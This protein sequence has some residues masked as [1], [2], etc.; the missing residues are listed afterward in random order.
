MKPESKLILEKILK[1][2]SLSVVKAYVEAIQ[3]IEQQTDAFTVKLQPK[4][5]G[6]P[7]IECIKE[8]R[9]LTGMGLKES[10]EMIEAGHTWT[11]L[12]IHEAQKLVSN[13]TRAGARISFQ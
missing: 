7:L 2:K 3:L 9:G 1:C 6:Q 12:G 11:G 8:L 10:K 4:F 13:M 5:D